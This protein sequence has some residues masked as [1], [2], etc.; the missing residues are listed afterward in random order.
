[1]RRVFK[2]QT[3]PGHSDFKQFREYSAEYL[4][5]RD[6]SPG[7]ATVK[8][9]ELTGENSVLSYF[10]LITPKQLK[11]AELSHAIPPLVP[12]VNW[13]S[14]QLIPSIIIGANFGQVEGLKEH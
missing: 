14:K 7:A 5:V 12:A 6:S 10:K 11:R 1:M 2:G 9:F 3:S 4:K 8:K 13:L